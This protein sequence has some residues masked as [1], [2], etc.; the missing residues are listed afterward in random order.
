[1]ATSKQRDKEHGKGHLAMNPPRS[2]H[3]RSGRLRG[4]S[5]W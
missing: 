4:S 1:M 2:C 3:S 5:S